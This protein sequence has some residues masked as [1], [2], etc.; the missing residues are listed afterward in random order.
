MFIAVYPMYLSLPDICQPTS[1]LATS[2]IWILSLLIVK[3]NN[4][5]LAPEQ[6]HHEVID[7]VRNVLCKS[8]CVCIRT[9]EENFIFN[10]EGVT[11]SWSISSISEFWYCVSICL[12]VA[13]YVQH[14]T[15]PL[16]TTLLPEVHAVWPAL[17]PRLDDPA[18]PVALRAWE[19]LMVMGDVS[20]EFLRKRVVKKVWPPLMRT[21]ES[22]ASRSVLSDKLYRLVEP[23]GGSCQTSDLLV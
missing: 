14:I 15:S 19:V 16:Q 8:V 5:H 1:R 23:A 3:Y 11:I 18:H 4:A 2:K 9:H 17:L 20:G 22:L 12:S 7:L 21:L 10:G 13:V 6:P